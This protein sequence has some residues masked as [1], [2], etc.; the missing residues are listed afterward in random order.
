MTFTEIYHSVIP[1]WGVEINFSDGEY[2][3]L[4][5]DEQG[6]SSDQLAALWNKVEKEVGYEN[7]YQELMVWTM[8]Q[9]FHKYA[10]S[11]FEEGTHYLYPQEIDLWEIEEQFFLNLSEPLW[12]KELAEYER[13]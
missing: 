2:L 1:F 6:F 7:S 9:I 10:K 13:F 11:L 8:Y 3:D 12:K 5:D 4:G